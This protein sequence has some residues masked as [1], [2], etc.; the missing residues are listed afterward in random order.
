MQ[1]VTL[2]YSEPMIRRAVRAFW[3]RTTGPAYFVAVLLVLVALCL[4]LARG[5]YSWWTGMLGSVL[6]LAVV[7]AASVY[8]VHL[9]SSL[10]RLRRMRTPEATLELDTDR[11]RV[12]SDAGMSELPW[13]VLTEIWCFPEFWLLFV[14]RAQFLTLPTSDLNDDARALILAS[15]AKCG[16]KVK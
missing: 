7:M 8:V 5:D 6:A 16:I 12:T 11:F 2:R 13:S 10:G 15:A 3:W 4:A 14:S 9:R 1:S